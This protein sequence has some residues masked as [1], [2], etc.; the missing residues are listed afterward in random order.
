MN[1]EFIKDIKRF[2]EMSHLSH[3]PA[4]STEEEFAMD[5]GWLDKK[6]VADIQERNKKELPEHMKRMK[7]LWKYI[8]KTYPKDLQEW[9]SLQYE[10]LDKKIQASIDGEDG[11]K[12]SGILADVFQSS[13]DRLKA[14]LKGKI[15][16][17][18]LSL[19]YNG[20]M[21]INL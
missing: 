18:D 10:Y 19:V 9:V 2:L 8:R 1:P 13:K 6:Q 20:L 7:S 14:L 15:S 16:D 4:T 5:R 11:T 21:K 12:P 3:S 17:K